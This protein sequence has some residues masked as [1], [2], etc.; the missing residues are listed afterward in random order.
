MQDLAAIYRTF[1]DVSRKSPPAEIK[2]SALIVADL[3]DGQ[4]KELEAGKLPVGLGGSEQ[5]KAFSE[6]FRWMGTHCP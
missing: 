6:V 3:M 5:Q 4:A 2:S 1:A